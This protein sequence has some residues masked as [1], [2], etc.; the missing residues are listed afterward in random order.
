MFNRLKE[1]EFALKSSPKYHESLDSKIQISVEGTI[2]PGITKGS[3]LQADVLAVLRTMYSREKVISEFSV[4]PSLDLKSDIFL[5]DLNIAVEVNGSSHY[6][7]ESSFLTP[8]SVFRY[9]LI[10]DIGHKT[11][12]VHHETWSKLKGLQ[13]KKEYLSSSIDTCLSV[14]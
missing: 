5:P 13:S 4:S 14:R 2:K 10:S 12:P 8:K 7:A 11:L 9:G 1:I 6:L 3:L